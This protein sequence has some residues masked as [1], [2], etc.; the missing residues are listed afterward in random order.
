MEGIEFLGIIISFVYFISFFMICQIWCRVII[1]NVYI[2]FLILKF[3]L[4][5]NIFFLL[6]R[7]L[8]YF[9]FE[10]LKIFEK[11]MLLDI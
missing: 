9:N 11:K 8:E 4:V 7:D 1:D 10:I 3:L 5:K 2:K 6:L